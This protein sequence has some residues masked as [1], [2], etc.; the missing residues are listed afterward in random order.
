MEHLVPSTSYRPR[1]IKREN[2]WKSR[3]TKILTL[4]ASKDVK[5][6]FLNYTSTRLCRI[7]IIPC[8]KPG[9]IYVVEKP[10]NFCIIFSLGT[11][12]EKT[13]R[14]TEKYFIIIADFGHGKSNETTTNSIRRLF[15]FSKIICQISKFWN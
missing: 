4:D 12:T 1:R 6:I 13:R 9:A 7:Q 11:I 2:F 10:R 14:I 15:N 3:T 8:E 5:A